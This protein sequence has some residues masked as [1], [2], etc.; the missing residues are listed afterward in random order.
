MLNMFTGGVKSSYSLDI[1]E[2]IYCIVLR[3]IEIE[4]YTQT[5]ERVVVFGILI[6]LK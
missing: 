3:W 2:I 5:N 1:V 4:F 6:M